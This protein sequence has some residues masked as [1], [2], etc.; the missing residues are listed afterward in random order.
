MDLL[1]E[2]TEVKIEPTEVKI[3]PTEVKIEPTEVNVFQCHFLEIGYLST[4]QEVTCQNKCA[5]LLH[6]LSR[7]LIFR[8]LQ[9][10][11]CILEGNQEF[12]F[13]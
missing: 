7:Q 11:I 10:Q 8:G 2:P 12:Y 3:E 6:K 4:C 5:A 1:I 9:L 13:L